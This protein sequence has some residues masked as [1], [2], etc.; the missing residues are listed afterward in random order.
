M[1]HRHIVRAFK[2]LKNVQIPNKEGNYYILAQ[3]YASCGTL[4]DL[5]KHNASDLTFS[6]RRELFHQ[7]CQALSYLHCKN[8]VHRD[9]KLDN[10][11]VCEGQDTLEIKIADFGFSCTVDQTSLVRSY[12][13]TKRGFMAPEIHKAKE[14]R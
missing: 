5:L 9:L 12:K 2:C 6:N 8:I 4:A 11:L 10:L 13:G 3:Q 14:D 7:V 1:T